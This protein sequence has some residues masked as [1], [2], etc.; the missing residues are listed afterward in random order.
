MKSPLIG[1]GPHVTIQLT[2]KIIIFM[3]NLPFILF[4]HILKLIYP[5]PSI[6]VELTRLFYNNWNQIGHVSNMNREINFHDY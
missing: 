1:V 6:H 2:M 5:S 4:Y 3:L